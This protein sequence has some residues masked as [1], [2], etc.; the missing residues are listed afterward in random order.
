MLAVRLGMGEVECLGSLLDDA[1]LRLGA[2]LRHARVS[3]D[4]LKRL[5]FPKPTLK[6][7]IPVRMMAAAYGT[8]RGYRVRYELERL[9]RGYICRPPQGDPLNGPLGH[10]LHQ[11]PRADSGRRGHC[12]RRLTLHDY[13][14]VCSW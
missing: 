10:G 9:S 3:G 14:V 12:A 4:T 2:A 6:V 11:H 13:A 5:R 1:T 7:S 8:F